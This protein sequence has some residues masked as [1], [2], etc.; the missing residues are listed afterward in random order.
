MRVVLCTCPPAEAELI[1]KALVQAGAACVNILPAVR[2]IYTWKG[3]LCDDAE[4]L[5]LIKAAEDRV[6]VLQETLRSVHPYELPEWVVLAPDQALTSGA[7]RA[8][9]EAAPRG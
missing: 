3:Q 4:A 9:V 2:S 5:L 8:W 1:A 6:A 7:Y